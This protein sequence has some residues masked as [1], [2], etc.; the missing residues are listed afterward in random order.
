VSK[1]ATVVNYIALARMRISFAGTSAAHALNISEAD[2]FDHNTS[3]RIGA[4]HNFS[5]ATADR[6]ERH[7]M[8]WVRRTLAEASQF[9]LMAHELDP[10]VRGFVMPKVADGSSLAGRADS[11]INTPVTD[12]LFHREIGATA[13]GVA[14]A[15]A[16]VDEELR[17]ADGKQDALGKKRDA[18]GKDLKEARN[19]LH[20]LRARIFEGAVST[21]GILPVPA[22]EPVTATDETPQ[23][24]ETVPSS[25]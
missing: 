18:A 1:A 15:G 22:Y 8:A 20:S 2:I 17:L 3:G 11:W 25:D 16:I 14:M 24:S 10:E 23:Y 19:K 9:L 12:Y 4:I 21:E 6:Q 5:S 13:Q 7:Q